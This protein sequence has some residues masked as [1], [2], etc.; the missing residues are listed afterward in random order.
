MLM[1]WLWVDV[2]IWFEA[3]VT[4]V[5]SREMAARQLSLVEIKCM[6]GRKKLALIITPLNPSLYDQHTTL[7]DT[8]ISSIFY[9]QY[10]CDTEMVI[11]DVMVVH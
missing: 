1:I 5:S 8:A 10:S 4:F 7:E 3:V 2:C 6:Q 11:S 9:A